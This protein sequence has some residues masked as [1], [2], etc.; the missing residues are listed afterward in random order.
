MIPLLRRARAE[1]LPAAV[2][3]EARC[4]HSAG[5]SEGAMRGELER[6]CGAFYVLED[7][8][9]AL[10]GLAIGWAEAGTSEVLDVAVDPERRREGLGRQLIEA[11]QDAARARG[12]QESFLEVRVDN[13][14]AIALYERLGYTR[15]GLRRRYYADGQDAL[16]M[17]RTLA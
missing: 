10:L 15:T 11:L 6:A 5:W 13:A 3:L 9:G 12:A 8:N 1:D 16:V 7:P 2:A 17:G 4:M 14:P